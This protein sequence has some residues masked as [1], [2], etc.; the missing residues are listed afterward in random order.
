MTHRCTLSCLDRSPCCYAALVSRNRPTRTA[1]RSQCRRRLSPTLASR[2]LL[3]STRRP[4]EAAAANYTQAPDVGA[5]RPLGPP[6]EGPVAFNARGAS[7]FV[8]PGV[9]PRSR[10]ASQA[11]PVPASTTSERSGERRSEWRTPVCTRSGY[12]L[13][14]VPTATRALTRRPLLHGRPFACSA[15]HSKSSH[16]SWPWAERSDCV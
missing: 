16:F 8:A 4:C 3:T 10:A 13:I 6:L 7:A 1:E 2:G 15:S 9:R 11:S 5:G 14:Q 12:G